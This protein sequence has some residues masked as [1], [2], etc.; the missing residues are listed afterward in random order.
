MTHPEHPIRQARPDEVSVVAS[1]IM[2]AM[3]EEC[4]AYYYGE[5]HTAQEFHD[6]MTCLVGRK[7][8]QYSYLNTLCAT[9]D[10]DRIVG[11]AV[12]YDG[13]RLKELRQAFIEEVRIRFGRDF[14]QMTE[15]T[16]AGELYIDSMAVARERRGQGVG[17][18]LFQAVESRARHLHIDTVGLLVD[19][20]NP[21]AERLYRSIGY[22]H[23]DDKDWGGHLLK[24]MQKEVK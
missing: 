23:V 2:E 1:L 6:M 3:R 4:C 16:Q 18:R 24:H 21:A 10:D 8:T 13:G 7:D 15:E 20:E 19:R 22:R 14:S 9:D 11:I 5:G 17:H 12:S